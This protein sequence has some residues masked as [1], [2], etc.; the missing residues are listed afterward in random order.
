MA[1]VAEGYAIIRDIQRRA[2][3]NDLHGDMIATYPSGNSYIHPAEKL[4]VAEYASL[5]ALAKVYGKKVV[6]RGNAFTEM[7]KQD[8]KLAI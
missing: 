3:K 1:T 6:H 7:K 8:G 2:L 5:W 4:P